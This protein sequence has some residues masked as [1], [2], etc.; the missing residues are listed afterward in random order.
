[1]K[2]TAFVVASILAVSTAAFAQ[3]PNTAE[4]AAP[5]SAPRPERP[6]HGPRGDHGPREGGKSWTRAD[7]MAR[8]GEHFDRV[9]TNKDGVVDPTER[10]AAHQKMRAMHEQ[11]K[12]GKPGHPG[13]PGE[14]APTG[15]PK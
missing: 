11:R 10:K 6:H 9:D 3:A 13:Q 14:A 15:T 12:A 7:A 8:A 4:N 5:G 2:S 1:M